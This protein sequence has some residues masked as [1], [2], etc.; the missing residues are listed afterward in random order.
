MDLG[1]TVQAELHPG[2]FRRQGVHHAVVEEGAVRGQRQL[3]RTAVQVR[4][5]AREPHCAF[6]DG[7]AQERLAAEK[8]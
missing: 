8:H 3:Q 2:A 7:E 5:F 4:V 1:G 6:E